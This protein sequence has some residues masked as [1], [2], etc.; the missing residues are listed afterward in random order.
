MPW[1]S[2]SVGRRERRTRCARRGCRLRRHAGSDR[3]VRRGCERGAP[4]QAPPDAQPLGRGRRRDQRRARERGAGQRRRTTPSTR[5]RAP[6]SSPIR[7]RSRSSATEAPADVYQLEHWG[8]V[9]SR[10]RGRPDRPAARSA[11]PPT[12]APPTPRTSPGHVLIQVLY[13]QVIKRNIPSTRSTSPGSSSRTA[14]A[15]WACIAWDLLRG[16][17]SAISAK[18]TMLATGGPGRLYTGTTNAYACTGDGMAMALRVGVPLKDMEMMQFHPTTLAPTGVLITEGCRGEGALLVNKDG[19]R[20][21]TRYA[22]HAME[23]ASRDVI[24]RAEQTEID[25][26]AGDRRQ[27]AARP[28]PPRRGQDPRAAARHPR[29]VA[30]LRGRRSD[31]RSDPCSAR[32]PLPDGRRRHRRLGPDLARRPL[33]GG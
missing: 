20:F 9:F 6:T 2:D 32:R 30:G 1:I 21:L 7:T 27:C 24:S 8:A 11:R 28:A 29:A 22:P 18:A 3:G 26:R 31:L 17:L 19:E 16:G 33:R 15:A 25:R 4:L 13:E 14:A 5:S 10:D 23:L 12:R